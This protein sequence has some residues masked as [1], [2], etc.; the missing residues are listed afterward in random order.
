LL[1]EGNKG[2]LKMKHFLVFHPSGVATHSKSA[3]ADFSL[4]DFFWASKRN[5]RRAAAQE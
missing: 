4:V 2:A 5:E 3:P 1:D